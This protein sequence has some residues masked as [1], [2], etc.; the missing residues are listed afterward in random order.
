MQLIILF[1]FLAVFSIL[2]AVFL[3]TA[4]YRQSPKFDLKRRLRR[5]AKERK[6]ESMSEG[7]RSEILKEVSPFDKFLAHIPYLNNLDKRLDHAGL[8]I[9]TSRFLLT[10]IAIVVFGFL[11]CFLITKMF[12]F[13]LLFVLLLIAAPPIYLEILKQ[14][15]IETFT[16]QFPEALTMIARSLRAGHSFTSAIQLIGQE[17]ADPVGELFKTAY[18]QQQLGL[19]ITDTLDNMNERMD[20]LDLRFFTTAIGINIEVG[21]NLA[22]ILDNLSHTIRERLRIR[23]Q[24]RVYTAQGRMSGYVLAALPLV[25]FIIFQFLLPNYERVMLTDDKGKYILMLAVF[26]QVIGFL[27][28][29]KIINIRI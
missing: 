13:S 17:I 2:A 29:R 20:S 16:E 22:E 4:E 5:M 9:S 11:F 14:K 3:G 18:D 15:R 7:L 19:R 24:I 27:F 12:W 10:V 8:K 21:G 23:R 6:A 1:T 25:T 28:I 26:M